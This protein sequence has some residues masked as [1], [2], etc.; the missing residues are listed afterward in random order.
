MTNTKE[1]Q[2]IKIFRNEILI[3]P[4]KTFTNTFK[5]CQMEHTKE[6]KMEKPLSIKIKASTKRALDKA[7]QKEDR[8]YSNI[9][10]RA[11]RKDFGL[12]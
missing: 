10:E 3:P 8:S 7:V 11:I 2:S 6:K 12:D 5:P 4:S 9:I 1:I